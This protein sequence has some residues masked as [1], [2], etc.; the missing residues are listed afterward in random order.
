M[1]DKE[2]DIKKLVEDLGISIKDEQ[3]NYK[4]FYVILEELSKIWEHIDV[5]EGLVEYD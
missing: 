2:F 1:N 3:G 5:E 4:S